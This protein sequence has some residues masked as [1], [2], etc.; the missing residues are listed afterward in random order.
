MLLEIAT[1]ELSHLEMV[2]QSLHMLLKGSP[3]TGRPGGRQLPQ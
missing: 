3:S 2:A 1:E